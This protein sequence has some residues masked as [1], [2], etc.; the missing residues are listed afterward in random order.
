MNHVSTN[1]SPTV[2]EQ[3][4]KL[5]YKDK[6]FITAQLKVLHRRKSR[7]YVKRGKSPKYLTQRDPTILHPRKIFDMCFRLFW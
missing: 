3:N 7:E 6:P 5:G 2:F 1:L 4:M